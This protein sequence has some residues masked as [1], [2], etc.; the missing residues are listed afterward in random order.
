M[1]PREMILGILP[2]HMEDKNGL[3]GFIYEN[4]KLEHHKCASDVE[5]INELKCIHIIDCLHS[6]KNKE[7]CCTGQDMSESCKLMMR[8]GSNIT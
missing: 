3:S 2:R 5:W 6:N 1:H 7:L 8:E 4:L